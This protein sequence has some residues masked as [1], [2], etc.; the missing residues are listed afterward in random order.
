LLLARIRQPLIEG[1]VYTLQA[2]QKSSKIRYFRTVFL[3]GVLN[4]DQ[5]FFRIEGNRVAADN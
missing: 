4:L 2:A 1:A 5:D 3:L